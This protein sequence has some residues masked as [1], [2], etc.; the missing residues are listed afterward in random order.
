[1][2]RASASQIAACRSLLLEVAGR[3]NG[4]VV[5]KDLVTVNGVRVAERIG[6]TVVVLDVWAGNRRVL[7]SV[8]FFWRD[9]VEAIVAAVSARIAARARVAEV[10]HAA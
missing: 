9:P 4:Q 3:V 10:A 6:E 2:S 7:G 1:V 8:S 5:Q